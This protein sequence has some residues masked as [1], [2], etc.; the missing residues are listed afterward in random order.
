MENPQLFQLKSLSYS[1]R[2]SFKQTL[3]PKVYLFATKI[4]PMPPSSDELCVVL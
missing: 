4:S 1:I 2:F 3:L